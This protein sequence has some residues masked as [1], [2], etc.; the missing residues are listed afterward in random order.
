MRFTFLVKKQPLPFLSH[1]NRRENAVRSHTAHTLTSTLARTRLAEAAYAATTTNL[2]PPC[3]PNARRFVHSAI[4]APYDSRPIIDFSPSH[5]HS[6]RTLAQ[7]ENH[8]SA[9]HAAEPT[10]NVNAKVKVQRART[11]G[12]DVM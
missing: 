2:P 9:L 11:H 12:R 3:R 4:L 8:P 1:I 6:T 5:T 10:L 7:K